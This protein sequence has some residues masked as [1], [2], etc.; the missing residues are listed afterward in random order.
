[1]HHNPEYHIATLFLLLLLALPSSAAE[2]IRITG[3]TTVLPI[4]AEA[5]KQYQAQHPDVRVTVSGGGSGV[6]VSSIN[7]GIA[8]IGMLSRSLTEGETERLAQKVNVIPI[9]YDAVTIAISKAIYEEGVTQL[10]IPQIAEIYRGKV[11]NWNRVGGPDAAI[12]VIDKETSRGT[13][14]VFAK[15]VLGNATARA[16]GA[17]IITGSNNEG[18]AAIGNSNQ[19]I[20]M[21]SSAWLNDRVRAV[22]I[23]RNG[24][25]TTP[26]NE[27]ITDGTYPIQRELNILVPKS[28]HPEVLAFIDFILSKQGQKIV[29]EVG[30]LPIK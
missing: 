16:P 9:A 6:G 15:V 12:L 19:A 23:S 30:Y 3:S 1:M 4:V 5:A 13:R 27:H 18:Q 29:Q 11:K 24:I 17:T 21:L 22:A 14:H 10:T 8:E 26:S 20:G 2:R 25:T 7:H 28:S